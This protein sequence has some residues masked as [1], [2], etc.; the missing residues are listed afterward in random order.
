M[1]MS[2]K[3]RLII[4]L[5]LCLV[6]AV[7]LITGCA[8]KEDK[9]PDTDITETKK[10]DE[11]KVEKTKIDMWFYPRYTVAG[12]ESGVYE[13]ELIDAYLKDN[14]NVTIDWEML[15]W[16]SGP[17]K[18][19][20]AITS[21]AMPDST[22]DYPG[23]IIGYGLEGALADMSKMV[24]AEIKA[25]IPEGIWD[26]C[27][28]GDKIYMYPTHVGP[29]VMGVN[30]KL[31]RDA[32]AEDLLPLDK[33]NRAWTIEEFEKALDAVKKLPNVEPIVFYAGNEQGDA[34]IRMFIQNF[35][36][37]FVDKDHTKVVINDEAGVKGLQWILDAYKK[38]LIA[39]GAESMTSTDALD[40][41]NQGRAAFCVM[42]GPGNMKT[43]NK[44]IEEGKAPKDFDFAF[45][46]QPSSDGKTLKVEAQVI[47][48]CIFDN[49]D[50]KKAEE[51][52]KFIEF[53]AE[54]K[55]N[56]L[57]TG[58]FPVR[59]SMGELYDHPELKFIGTMTNHLADT[60]YTVRNYAK[61][62]AVWYPELQAALTG[63]KTA[64]QALDDF[65]AKGTEIMNEK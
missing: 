45:V 35:G 43:L 65:A 61:V 20:I 54:N 10:P 7:G 29:V 11:T 42:Y 49:K 53:L 34:S 6:M 60:G 56:V 33:P 38:G 50:A 63:A 16:N 24:S 32:G 40:W 23:R 26:H 27:M 5:T 57:A 31:F 47:G 14:P 51:T 55:E 15:A 39:K 48:Y 21:N 8:K 9:K 30:R 1:Y 44:M 19:N 64:K 28:V 58:A 59:K 41:F 52:F 2:R 46:P 22:F 12:K 18:I 4:A 36:A 37:D 3:V 25:D 13:Q 62:R 17:E